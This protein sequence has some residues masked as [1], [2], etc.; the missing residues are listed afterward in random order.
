MSSNFSQ[1][2]FPGLAIFITVLSLN[3]LGDGLR[4]AFDPRLSRREA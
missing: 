1:A 3:F 4:I 2:F